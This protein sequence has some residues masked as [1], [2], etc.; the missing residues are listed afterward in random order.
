MKKAIVIAC[1]LCLTL[2]LGLALSRDTVAAG[3]QPSGAPIRIGA[4]FAVTGNSS[5]L[6]LPEKQTVEML[7]EQINA[8]GGI[9]GRPLEV[10]IYDDEGDE[11]KTVMLAKRLISNDNVVAVIGPTTSG[12]SMAIIDT[13]TTAKIPLVS[14]AAS[15]KIVTDEQGKA[16]P[17]IFKT[18]QSDSMAVSRIFEYLTK[19]KIADVA[20]MSVSNGYGDS[21]RA[22]LSRLAPEFK[23]KISADERFGQDD[24]DMTAQLTRIKGTTAKAIIV[25]GTQKAPA[26]IAK[27][28]KT[29]G[30][31][32]L[33][34]QSHGVASKK[35]IELAGDAANGQVLPAGRLIVVDQLAANDPM[36]ALLK[37]YRD[38]YE[39]RFKS[40]VSTFGG[41][42]YDALMLLK[43]AIEKAKSADPAKI[44]DALEQ[45]KKFNGTA[46]VFNMSPTNH[47]GLTKD[48]FVMVR[49][50]N[51]DWKLIK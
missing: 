41:H 8:A 44:R 38:D 34:V 51:N 39:G 26:I 7:V 36:K 15:Y 42:A 33:L 49:I 13:M 27:N 31:T 43:A 2:G 50:E 18:P 6:G 40:P 16:R 37:K 24:V 47:N 23:I 25:W 48:A 11:T 45:I 20:I 5:S 28:A 22:E 12:T 19:Q 35:F 14:C 9:L 10:V 21:G 4:I 3:N 1:A 46:G 17:W 32:Q 30:L 29:L